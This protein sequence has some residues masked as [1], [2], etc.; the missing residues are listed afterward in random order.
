MTS[1]LMLVYLYIN[2][3]QMKN[4]VLYYHGD[5]MWS[6]SCVRGERYILLNVGAL[7]SF[8]W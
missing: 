1:V 3:G 2:E 5:G 4:N 6:L 8:W 7:C